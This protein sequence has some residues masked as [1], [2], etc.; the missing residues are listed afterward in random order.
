[1][2]ESRSQ[3]LRQISKTSPTLDITLICSKIPVDKSVRPQAGRQIFN[4][5]Q[6][7]VI[8]SSTYDINP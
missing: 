4:F 6:L 5:R 3:Y 8:L 7:Q 2:R 1:V